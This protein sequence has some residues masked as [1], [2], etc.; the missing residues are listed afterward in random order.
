MNEM[1]NGQS[2]DRSSASPD[3][4]V[5]RLFQKFA[6]MYGGAWAD[7]WAGMPID[8]V[9]GEW[10]RGLHGI[11]MDA[12]R[13]A[14]ENIM[15]EGKPFPP[16]LPEFVSLC[17]QFTRRGPHRLALVDN[18]RES[19]PDSVRAMIAKLRKGAK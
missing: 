11:D 3:A 7:K 13:L 5:D 2:T 14:L 8:A 16:S 6:L 19:M 17:R 1:T 18:T 9:K 10:T 12:M 15:T 4:L